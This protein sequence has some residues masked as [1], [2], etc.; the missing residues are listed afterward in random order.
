MKIYHNIPDNKNLFKNPIV[1]IG[2]FDGVHLGHQKIFNRLL[3]LTEKKGGDPV[4]IT[5]S[6]HPRKIL[7]PDRSLKFLTTSEEKTNA[8]F[9]FGID[10]IILLNFTKEMANMS[11]EDF[12]YEILLKKIDTKDLVI[13]YDHA[14][15]KN[16]E[17]NI[18]FLTRLSETNGIKVTRVGEKIF[19]SKPISSTWIRNEIKT[20]NM[21]LVAKLLNRN[22]TITG[23]VVKGEGRGKLLGY[24]T[25]NILPSHED[26][27]V[28]GDGVY[29]ASIKF[30]NGIKKFGMLNIGN[31][32]TFNNKTKT[33]EINIF[34]F[35]ENVYD[36]EVIIEFYEKIRKELTFKS[37]K[38]LVKQISHDKIIVLEKL[39]KI[40]V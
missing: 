32:P 30:D 37:K 26:K 14:F 9:N 40:N 21:S 6:K 23:T 1:T 20:G 18:D 16:R 19:N 29:A 3:Y 39:K 10:N 7:N 12:Y 38:E 22:Y 34:D 13:G 2:N 4:V 35:D 36:S 17:G 25:A 31:N 15:G 24:P 28:P 27:L 11:A 5:F 33:I 8:I